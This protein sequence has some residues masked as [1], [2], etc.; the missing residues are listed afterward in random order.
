MEISGQDYIQEVNKA[1][2]GIWVVLHLYKQGC[3]YVR[4]L[5]CSRYMTVHVFATL[6]TIVILCN[7]F[8]ADELTV[9]N[10]SQHP[11][12]HADQSALVLIGTEV[13]RH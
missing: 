12:V 13:S 4:I 11:P 2:D 8:I 10:I 1:G 9:I 3:V 7:M 6:S 5:V